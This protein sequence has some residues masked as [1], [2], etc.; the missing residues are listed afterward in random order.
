[1]I[2]LYSPMHPGE[3]IRDSFLSDELNATTLA[4][5]LKVSPSTLNRVLN[6]KSAVSCEMALR[7]ERVLGLD[8]DT[9]LEMQNQYELFWL[10][11]KLA[12]EMD[13]LITI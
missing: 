9:W 12:D 3:F 6:T 8:A 2:N 5:H 1:M 11:P 4:K 13:K 10:K 7:L